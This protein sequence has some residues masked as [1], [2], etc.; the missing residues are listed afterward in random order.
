MPTHHDSLHALTRPTPR[1]FCGTGSP[2]RKVSAAASCA[3]RRWARSAFPG[4]ALGMQND[5][6]DHS[7]DGSLML[8]LTVDRFM[9]RHPQTIS[10]GDTLASA[11]RLMRAHDIRHLPVLDS[12]KLVGLLSIGD[13]HLIETLKDVDPEVVQV[14]EAM[15]TEV[16]TVGLHSSL[17]HT[18]AEMATRKCGA[19]VVLDR[20][21]IV[22]VFTTID[23]LRALSAL[24][25][26]SPKAAH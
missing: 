16:Y 7:P 24:L 2:R 23:A 26:Q 22:G 13:L 6:P 9:T 14:S 19:A 20:M 17:R 15:T 1:R 3:N 25:E 18:A 12:G 8:N 21:H 11:H 4:L 10:P 5:L